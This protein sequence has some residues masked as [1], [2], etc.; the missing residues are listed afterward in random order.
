MEGEADSFHKKVP[1]LVSFRA[2]VVVELPP[3][4]LLGL[5]APQ[6]FLAEVPLVDQVKLSSVC[7]VKDLHEDPVDLCN[8]IHTGSLAPLL[9]GRI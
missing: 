9:L 8:L 7:P 2:G 6:H 5:K 3:F 1:P 4:C